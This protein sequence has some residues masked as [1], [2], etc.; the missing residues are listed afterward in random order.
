MKL[1]CINNTTIKRP[2]FDKEK[3]EKHPVTFCKVYE[4]VII[5]EL[6]NSYAGDCFLCYTDDKCWKHI[7]LELFAPVE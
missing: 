1:M 4:G 7:P 6:V 3:I 2:F 5:S